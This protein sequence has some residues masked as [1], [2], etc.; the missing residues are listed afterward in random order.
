M[1]DNIVILA[2]PLR[3]TTCDDL[4]ESL[5]KLGYFNTHIHAI[6]T[7]INKA[8]ANSD[9]ESGGGEVLDAI[10]SSKSSERNAS[11]ACT[12]TYISN[13]L[14]RASDMT[15]VGSQ[16]ETLDD[17]R[18]TYATTPSGRNAHLWGKNVQGNIESRRNCCNLY[19]VGKVGS[20]KC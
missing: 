19:E 7:C 1:I 10:V 15:Q 8:P 14:S 16:S 9:V 12:G 5:T 20:W 3:R 11:T 6:N 4:D 2:A 13:V 17:R 18:Q